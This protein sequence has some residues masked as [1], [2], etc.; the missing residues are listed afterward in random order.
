VHNHEA[1]VLNDARQLLAGKA[2]AS[3]FVINLVPKR[4]DRRG[5]RRM[6]NRFREPPTCSRQNYSLVLSILGDP[7]KG[8]DELRMILWREA[9]R[10]AIAVKFDN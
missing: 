6:R 1:G 10:Y 3:E 5:C 2:K 8:I 4:R 7:V 9:E